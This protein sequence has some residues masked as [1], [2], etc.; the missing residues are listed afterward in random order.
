[1]SDIST[2]F[3]PQTS[4]FT[5]EFLLPPN[6]ATGDKLHRHVVGNND[7]KDSALILTRLDQI[8]EEIQALTDSSVKSQKRLKEVEERLSQIES[9]LHRV[10]F[11]GLIMQIVCVF[12]LLL[13]GISSLI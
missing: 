1:M 4:K 3:K 12:A 9:R 2:P 5:N 13:F 8:H 7:V 10:E 11:G 6:P